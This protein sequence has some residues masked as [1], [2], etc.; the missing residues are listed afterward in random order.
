MVDVDNLL[1]WYIISY[2]P[3]MKV[4]NICDNLL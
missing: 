4:L 1:V 2:N 3:H